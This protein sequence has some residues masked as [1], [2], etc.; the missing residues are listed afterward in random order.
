MK[1]YDPLREY[2][3]EKL[4]SDGLIEDAWGAVDLFERTVAEYTG[5]KYAVSVDNCTDAIFL[6]L[7]YLRCDQESVTIA[8][9]ERTYCSIPMTIHNAGCNY[10][11]KDFEWSGAYQLAPYPIYDS[12]LRLTKGMYVKD[13]FQCLSFH[14]RKILKL[15]KGGMILTDNLEAA[16]WFKTARCKGRHPHRKTFYKDE[17]FDTM[18]WNMYLHPEDAAKAYLILEQLPI[19]NE[20]GGGSKSYENLTKHKIFLE[21]ETR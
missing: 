18:G 10:K 6:C 1:D 5:S 21:K 8:I 9:P 3:L 17:K 16:E 13:T 14:R 20:D 12:A 19:N 4:K 15:T 2:A 11:F 7:K